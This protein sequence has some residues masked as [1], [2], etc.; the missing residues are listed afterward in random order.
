MNLKEILSG[1]DVEMASSAVM[2]DQ[3][4]KI[5]KWLGVKLGPQLREFILEF[6]YVAV[7]DTPIL[8]VGIITEMGENNIMVNETRRMREMYDGLENYVFIENE[9]IEYVDAIVDGDDNVFWID[10]SEESIIDA[11]LKLFDY[12][13]LRVKYGDWVFMT[14]EARAKVEMSEEDRLRYADA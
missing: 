8:F 7:P 12:I 4:E 11:E 10:Y 1:L 5:E 2:V 14:D 9:A 6:R 3:V 13:Y